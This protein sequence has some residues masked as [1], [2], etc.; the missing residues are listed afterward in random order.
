MYLRHWGLSLRP[1]SNTPDPRF[2]YCSRGHEEAL[3]RLFY[4]VCEEKGAMV[5][6]GEVGCGKTL[7]ARCFIGELDPG[8]FELAVIARAD[9]SPEELLGEIL[10]QFGLQ[11]G[12]G[13]LGKVMRLARYAEDLR[14]AGRRAVVIIDECQLASTPERLEEIRLLLN[15]Q[16]NDGYNLTLVLMGQPEFRL[17]LRRSPQLLQ[18]MAIRYH[19]GPL[20]PDETPAYL[21]HRLRLAGAR[22][23]VFT[24]AAEERI[25]LAARGV[26]REINNLCDLA[27]M[28]AC[29]RR[30]A[31]VDE[32]VIAETAQDMAA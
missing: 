6:T 13:H 5:L 28:V 10:R 32:D 8:R 17:S 14:A 16:R 26:P 20:A 27:M 4:T 9:L 3:T 7:L 23:L 31:V 22:R 18:R 15:M 21:R 19:L 11:G 12:A 25:H 24:P 2:I 1:F 29:G 30:K